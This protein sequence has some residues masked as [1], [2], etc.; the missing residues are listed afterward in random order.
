MS[1]ENI[2]TGAG[3]GSGAAGSPCCRNTGACILVLS[4]PVKARRGTHGRV[5]NRRLSGAHWPAGVAQSVSFR[6]GRGLSQ[7]VRSK[8]RRH[9]MTTWVLHAHACILYIHMHKTK[10]CTYATHTRTHRTWTH[11]QAPPSIPLSQCPEQLPAHTC[12]LR[13]SLLNE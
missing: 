6:S 13:R 8:Q 1:F 9:P 10:T 7:R 11:V 2:N 3:H 5:V 12:T 4:I